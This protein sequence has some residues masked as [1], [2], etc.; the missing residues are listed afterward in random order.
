MPRFFR[1]RYLGV[2]IHQ[3]LTLG[4]VVEGVLRFSGGLLVEGTIRGE[5]TPLDA[6]SDV[7]IKPDGVVE[8]PVLQARRVVIQGTLRAKR[9]Q[10]GTLVLGESARVEA[11][12]SAD[13]LEIHA[14][15]QYRGRAE[16]GPAPA[17][18]ETDG[19]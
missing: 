11:D 14:G 3:T 9:V 15:A 13:R 7:V 6:D 5:L 1:R 8:V 18:A 4:T 10:A 19:A 16:C 2:P 12:L 17:P